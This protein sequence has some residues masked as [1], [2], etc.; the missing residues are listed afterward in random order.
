MENKEQVTPNTQDVIN[1]LLQNIANLT[2]ENAQ[3]KSVLNQYSE[4]GK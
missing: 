4:N 3:L 2:V 1:S